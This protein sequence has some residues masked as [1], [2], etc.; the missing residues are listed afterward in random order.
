M[1]YVMFCVVISHFPLHTLIIYVIDHVI[2]IFHKSWFL[3]LICCP[4]Y[5][6]LI[7][8]YHIFNRF[9]NSCCI[10]LMSCLKMLEISAIMKG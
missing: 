3:L 7:F 5:I 10:I 8:I 9:S 6:L 2:V 1:F 4:V